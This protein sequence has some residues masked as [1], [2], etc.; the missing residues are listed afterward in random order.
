VQ[1]YGEGVNDFRVVEMTH[2]GVANDGLDYLPCRYGSSRLLFRGPHRRLDGRYVV[3]VGGTETYGKYVERPYPDLLGERI[4]LPVAN[5]GAVN[6]GIDV[7]ASDR[8]VLD[9]C[10]GARAVV[11]QAMGAHNLHNRFYSVHPRR[12][13][14]FLRAAPELRALYPD[15]DFTEFSFT[16]HL[17]QTLVETGPD[18]FAPVL[19]D[20]RAAWLTRM[21]AFLDAVR[22][23]VVLLWMAERLP[24][25]PSAL[26]RASDP[27]FVTSGMIDDIRPRLA[28]VVVAARGRTPGRRRVGLH[29]T[30]LD[31][32]AAAV[33]PDASV[34]A[35]TA[36]ALADQLRLF[37]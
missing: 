14:R 12:N 8:A 17:I 32:P 28:G 27:L 5:F 24:E 10:S 18:R 9:A 16:R 21:T 6:A 22:A 23:P 4:G 33:V 15:I 2:A 11:L 19:D 35:E 7:F 30:D 26:H 29:C 3:A 13:D 31:A 1:E 36:R 20:L 37:V 34:H 25:E